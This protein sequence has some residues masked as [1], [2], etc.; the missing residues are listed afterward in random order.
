MPN[1]VLREGILKSR[2]VQ[3]VSDSARLLYY[4]LISVVDD[5]GRCDFD[6]HVIRAECFCFIMERWPEQRIA[7]CMH[8]LCTVVVPPNRKPLIRVYEVDGR[9]YFQIEKFG[10]RTQSKPR[11]PGPPS[12]EKRSSPEEKKPP[13][14][15]PKPKANGPVWESSKF[16][17]WWQVWSEIRGTAR[18]RPAESAFFSCVTVA[19]EAACMDCTRS[20]L[21]SLDSPNKGFNPDNFL[22]EQAKDSFQAR[23]PAKTVRQALS[24]TQQ[25]IAEAKRRKEMV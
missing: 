18:R 6:E 23:W 25:A 14:D 12:E 10:Q 4:C 3:A 2:A 20:Y 8:E 22:F 11:Y 17:E 19:N 24:P 16:E 21:S 9:K 7:E 13:V 1:R 15:S 5:F